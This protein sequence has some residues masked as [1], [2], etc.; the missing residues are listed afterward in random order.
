MFPPLAIRLLGNISLSNL[1]NSSK[2]R[3]TMKMKRSQI[4][5]YSQLAGWR[6]ERALFVVAHARYQRSRG[7]NPSESYKDERNP[8]KALR[9][10]L[11]NLRIYEA[12]AGDYIPASITRMAAIAK[13]TNQ[14]VTGKFNDV[15]ITADPLT[16]A[17]TLVKR[18]NDGMNRNHEE[19]RKSPEYKQRQ[20]ERA[21]E[22]LAMRTQVEG[23]M[24]L[25]ETLNFDD[26]AAVID[27]FDGIREA[28]DDVDVMGLVPSHEI[29]QKFEKHGYQA[30][31]NCGD[32]FDSE[33]KENVARYLVGQAL[34]CMKEFGAIHQVY[35]H[36]AEEWRKKFFGSESIL[37]PAN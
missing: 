5:A 21:A 17:A 20:E 24:Q 22:V 32:E 10:A 34:G 4:S 30:H 2:R 37:E 8:F 7:K 33:N 11:D 14:E 31:A 27:W 15:T 35:S 1:Q 18:W 25:L 36:M 16:A 13:L 29:V 19:Y 28:T 12:M 26:L 3:N 6:G 23:S 9:L